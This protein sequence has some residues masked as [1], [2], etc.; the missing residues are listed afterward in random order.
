MESTTSQYY[1][2]FHQK[3][4]WLCYTQH[5]LQWRPLLIWHSPCNCIDRS[6]C[7]GGCNRGMVVADKYLERNVIVIFIKWKL[8]WY[9]HPLRFHIGLFSVPIFT[10]CTVAILQILQLYHQSRQTAKV[11]LYFGI[12]ILTELFLALAQCCAMCNCWKSK[13][14]KLNQLCQDSD[15]LL[16]LNCSMISYD[17]YIVSATF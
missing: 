4:T 7:H 14:C 3:K 10:T 9:F 2:I 16:H 8:T 12:S 5:F 17:H 11:Q 1:N 13:S 15:K 6:V